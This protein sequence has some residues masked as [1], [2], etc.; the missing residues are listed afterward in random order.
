MSITGLVELLNS[1]D[2]GK[3]GEL[4]AYAWPGGYA[5]YYLTNSGDVLCAPCATRDLLDYLSD[6][7]ETPDA[8]TA[9]DPPIAYGAIGATE[10]PPEDGEDLTCDN[11]HAVIYQENLRPTSTSQRG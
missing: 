10:D 11:C 2:Q 5:I 3:M 7:T 6:M 9:Y 4:P 8:P 1:D